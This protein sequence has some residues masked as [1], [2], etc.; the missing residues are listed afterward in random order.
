MSSVILIF[1]DAMGV[2]CARKWKL[3]KLVRETCPD[4]GKSTFWTRAAINLQIAKSSIFYFFLN[5]FRSRLID[6]QTTVCNAYQCPNK[7]AFRN[8]NRGTGELLTTHRWTQKMP[9]FQMKQSIRNKK[10][11]VVET[12]FF[13][14]GTH[15]QKK[16][17][18][19][20]IGQC[21]SGKISPFFSP[22]GLCEHL[23]ACWW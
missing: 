23:W 22:G 9:T 20:E 15:P 13:S 19:K 8:L 7:K 21:A 16:K 10:M 1:L 14:S 17:K 4:K 6:N 11:W 5:P 2:G 18:R 12:F 3:E